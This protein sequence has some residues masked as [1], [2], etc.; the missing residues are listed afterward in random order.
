LLVYFSENL[1]TAV[2]QSAQL[3]RVKTSPLAR[4]VSLWLMALL[5]VSAS[6]T[7][8]LRPGL[9][10]PIVPPVVPWPLAAVHVSGA[11]ECLLGI[12][13]LIPRLS[14]LAALG[15]VLLLVAVFPANV[16][17]W[18]GNVRVDGAVAPG[19]YH[20]VRL[21]LQV[22]LIAWAFWLSRRPPEPTA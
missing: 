16:Y 20:A 10:V 7:H 21:P 4:R 6:A 5:L 3:T 13:L 1:V 15:V 12:G 22:L 19:W 17:H 2:P 9:F 14:R 8:F 18:L 11:A